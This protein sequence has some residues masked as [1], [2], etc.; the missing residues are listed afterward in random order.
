MVRRILITVGGTGGHI[1]PAIAV[2]QKLKEQYSDIYV[3]FAGGGLSENRFFD[4]QAFPYHD[5]ACGYF[6]LKNPLKC[7]KSLGKMALGV[8][9]SERVIKAFKPDL[10]IGF[11]S[12][13]SLPMLI[14]SKLLSVPFILHEAN[15]IPGKVNRLL[16]RYALATGV[17]FPE[18]S[19][20]LKGKTVPV[21][22]PLRK[23]MSKA[24]LNRAESFKH[25]GLSEKKKTLLVFGGSQ[26]AFAINKVMCDALRTYPGD[27]DMI[28]VLHFSGHPD[29]TVAV[30]KAYKECGVTAC[31]RDY[32]PFMQKAWSIADLVI[33]RAGAG[34][35]AEEVE[36]EVPGLLIPY[37]HATDDHQ[38]KNAEHMVDVI[39]GA[40][41][42]LEKDL[43]PKDLA[44]RVYT[45]LEEEPQ[46]LATMKS[47][48][49]AF[50]Q[51]AEH[52]D[53]NSLIHE[54]LPL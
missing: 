20:Y 12:Y 27:F 29:E 25:Y 4:G 36:F 5:I 24:A 41:M 52:Y 14:A 45:L 35:I 17:H 31:V 46:Q 21:G 50:K 16:S 32:E 30:S 9:Q 47:A 13:H 19:H 51:N 37:P 11:G 26:G 3:A 49:V 38:R 43:D 22:M 1:F 10:V 54:I 33:S 18:A 48:I 28:Q 39:N 42:I 15:T 44:K 34:T 53:L 7:I 23:E 6:P 8:R 40:E 2:A